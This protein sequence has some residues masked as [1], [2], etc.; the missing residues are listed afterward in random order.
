[1]YGGGGKLDTDVDFPIKNLDL[2]PFILHKDG[3]PVIY[4]LFAV[5]N[6]YGNLGFGHY[7]AFALNWKE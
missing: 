4:D 6:H 3:K 7:T 1:M 5:S 2:G